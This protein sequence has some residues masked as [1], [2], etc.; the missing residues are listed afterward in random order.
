MVAGPR[1]EIV[2]AVY[3]DP[4]LEPHRFEI[5]NLTVCR[6]GV[7]AAG[8]DLLVTTDVQ[9]ELLL[10][11]ELVIGAALIEIPNPITEEVDDLKA[12]IL[13]RHRGGASGR[14]VAGQAAVIVR[15]VFGEH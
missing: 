1:V 4:V 6:I 7:G 13:H 5:A 12:V 10:A 2:A 3:T 11:A 15:S 14:D 8:I 9:H